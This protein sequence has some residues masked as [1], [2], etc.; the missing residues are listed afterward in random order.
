MEKIYNGQLSA[1]V[2]LPICLISNQ[3]IEFGSGGII[4]LRKNS[5]TGELIESFEVSSNQVTISARELLI[6]PS[7]QLPYETEIFMVISDGFVISSVNGSSFSGFDINGNKEFKFTTEDPIGKPLDGGTIISKNNETYTIVSP[8]KSEI[9]LTW[10]EFSKAVQKTDEE[11]GT[12]GWYVPSLYELQNH[13]EILKLEDFYWTS[14]ENDLGTAYKLNMSSNI[15]FVANKSESYLIRTF[16]K[17][18]Y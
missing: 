7:Q 2:N 18:N 17:V 1:K 15:S 5:K 9:N 12:K 10:Y 8:K 6:K 11:T 4:E 16:K 3:Q 13:K 14:T